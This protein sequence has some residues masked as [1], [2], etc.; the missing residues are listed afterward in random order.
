MTDMKNLFLFAFSILGSSLLGTTAFAAEIY[1]YVGG[2]ETNL[3]VDVA[4]RRI[5]IVHVIFDYESCGERC[6]SS[7][8]MILA[9]PGKLSRGF[10][11]QQTSNRQSILGVACDNYVVTKGGL[12]VTKLCYSKAHGI[13]A[14]SSPG[15]E[16]GKWFYSAQRTGLFAR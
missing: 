9:A 2:M 13:M 3:A 5:V 4:E 8:F 15:Y 12:L 10:A 6:I 11:L 1:R 14:F 16:S 7:D